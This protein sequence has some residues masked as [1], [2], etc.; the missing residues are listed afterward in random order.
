MMRGGKD[1]VAAGMGGSFVRFRNR[2]ACFAPSRTHIPLVCSP[3]VMC[4]PNSVSCYE[5][6]EGLDAGANDS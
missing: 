4:F 5:I 3:R 6:N 2:A 1:G